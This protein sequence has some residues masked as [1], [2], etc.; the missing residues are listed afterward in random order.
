MITFLPHQEKA[1]NELRSGSIL[2]GGVGSGKSLTSLGYFLRKECGCN[3]K[4]QN[5][6]DPKDLLIITIA[7]KRDDKEWDKECELLGLSQDPEK[8]LAGIKV[9]IDSWNNIKKYLD[10]HNGFVIFDEQKVVGA[11]AWV[12]AFYK[13]TSRNRWILLTATPGDTWID[14]IPV[15]VANG[16]YRNKS[17]FMFQHAVYDRYSKYP[18]VSK[19]LDV[20]KLECVR[21]KV[22]VEMPFKKTNIKHNINVEVDYNKSL[23]KTIIKD[24]WNPYTNLPVSSSSEL[25]SLMRKVTNSDPSRLEMVL[26]I[27]KK[28]PRLIIFYSFDYELEILKTLKESVS[29]NIGIAEWNGHKHEDIPQT[30]KWIYLVNYMSGAEGWECITTDTIVFYSQQYSYRI[31]TQSAGRIDRLNSPYNDLYYYWL[32]SKAWIDVAIGRA[33]SQKRDFNERQHAFNF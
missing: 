17:D 7:K 2:L 30:K 10:F 15:F 22:L 27:F 24:R 31:A 1:I 19:W 26:D 9:K 18:R 28:H 21:R 8:S 5:I 23:Y 6:K 11:G 13:I 4:C 16:Y 12:K 32:K 20:P 25:Y 33:I 29:K 14:Y 3:S